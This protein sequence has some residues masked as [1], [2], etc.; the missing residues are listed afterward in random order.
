MKKIIGIFVLVIMGSSA[1]IYVVHDNHVSSVY[2]VLPGE[3]YRS[4]QLDREGVE[5]A[6]TSNGIRSIINLRGG[7]DGKQWYKDEKDVAAA[8]N[9][10]HHDMSFSP[11]GLP[12]RRSVRQ[13]ADLL[14]ATEK[15]TLVHCKNGSDRAGLASAIA[16]LL[17]EG[18]S[19]PSVSKHVSYNYLAFDPDSTGRLFYKQ[20]D[21]WLQAKGLAHT[22]SRFRDWLDNDYVDDQGNFLYY[23]DTINGTVWLNGTRYEDGYSFILKRSKDDSLVIGGWAFDE[24]AMQPVQEVS[25]WLDSTHLGIAQYGVQR[26]GVAA[27]YE[28]KGLVPSGWHYSQSLNTIAN[29]CYALSLELT[30]ED[31]TS[32]R[33]Q[34]QARICI[35]D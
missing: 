15:P 1:L 30:R 35:E 34:P 12:P 21:E 18:Q 5:L 7:N 17:Q 24:K 16:M 31:G 22:A 23:I 25:L 27:L 10:T 19:L 28:H 11:H 32:W 8:N 13:L 26:P 2:P 20:Y 3:V 6:I 4:A 14:M 9:V 29:G 33:S